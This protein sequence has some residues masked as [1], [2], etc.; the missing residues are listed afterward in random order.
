[1]CCL[2]MVFGVLLVP[3]PTTSAS[4]LKAEVQEERMDLSAGEAVYPVVRLEDSE[5]ALRINNVLR[6]EVEAFAQRIR[7]V[8]GMTGTLR[9]RITCNKADT[10]SCILEEEW[11]SKGADPRRRFK[12][13][14]F[15]LRSG[16]QAT[17]DDVW[18]LAAAAGK[19]KL[20][21]RKGLVDKLYDQTRRSGVALYPEFQGLSYP[22][23]NLY[24]DDKLRI[25][26]LLQPGEVTYES[27]G[28]VDI[29]LDEEN[30]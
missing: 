1:M 2:L 5:G 6:A 29:D 12:A 4:Q 19:K 13:Y 25:H 22:P 7:A 30:W 17:Y 27:A 11:G 23:E 18:A 16:R 14:I 20:Y 21:D 9:Y 28:A 10:F 3:A 26:M 8:Q 15:K 24:M